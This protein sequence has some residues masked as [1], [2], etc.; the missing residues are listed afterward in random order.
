MYLFVCTGNTC[1]SPM[2]Q[3]LWRARGHEAMSAGLHATDGSCASSGA[4]NAIQH[5]GLDISRHRAQNV[6]EAL[7]RSADKVV[8]ISQRHALALMQQFPRYADKI[9]AMPRDIADPFGGDDD[10]YLRCA[11]EIYHALDQLK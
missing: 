9:I 1:R 11:E 2:A 6:T 7:I 8:G 3:A 10:D 4:R 5:M